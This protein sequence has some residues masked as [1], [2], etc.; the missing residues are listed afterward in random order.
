M[1]LSRFL[2]PIRLRD[3]EIGCEK[4]SQDEVTVMLEFAEY[5]AFYLIDHILPLYYSEQTAPQMLGDNYRGSFELSAVQDYMKQS[6][7]KVCQLLIAKSMSAN[8]PYLM[9]MI[10]RGASASGIELGMNNIRI[11]VK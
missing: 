4:N 11:M 9:Q 6:D 1:M 5:N 8:R 10:E 3:M 2:G 7:P